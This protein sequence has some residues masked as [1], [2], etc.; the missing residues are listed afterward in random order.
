MIKNSTNPSQK[1]LTTLQ[2]SLL[3][4]I[5]GLRIVLSFVPS[6]NLG[7]L[8]QLGV[9]FIGA[10]LSGALFGP[11]YA[12]I[13]SLF[14]DLITSLL[15]GKNI[16]LGFT[17]SAGLGGL[18]YGYFLYRKP[19]SWKNI[20]FAVLSVTLI[21]NLGLNSIWIKMMYGK[22]WA[23]FMPMRIVKNTLS[24]PLNTII[25]YFVFNNQTVKS[26]INKYQF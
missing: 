20:F 11:W 23:V 18:F 3:G 14:N 13:L 26:F 6:I 2:V 4:I 12:L 8:V 5:L 25:L 9:G 24:L 10:A 7:N 15:Q 1:R 22:A 16:F 17:L 21:I 19:A